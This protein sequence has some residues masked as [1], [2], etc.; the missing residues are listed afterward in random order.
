[1]Q[2]TSLHYQFASV[3]SLYSSHWSFVSTVSSTLARSDAVNPHLQIRVEI[4]PLNAS[5]PVFYVQPI[6]EHFRKF[7]PS[8]KPDP[9]F[10]RRL[11]RVNSINNNFGIRSQLWALSRA[12][13]P[14][15]SIKWVALADVQD[16]I[17]RMAQN[18]FNRMPTKWSRQNAPPCELDKSLHTGGAVA[19][20]T[21]SAGLSTERYIP[22]I[23]TFVS[24]TVLHPYG[25][26][27]RNSIV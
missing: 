13:V 3:S 21:L 16:Q 2:C 26:A 15:A 10:A 25:Q 20:L 4:D 11:L 27:L 19:I 8:K 22:E 1:L 23:H 6:Q 7:C 18:N 5:R 9:R 14:R 12:G 17:G 24:Y